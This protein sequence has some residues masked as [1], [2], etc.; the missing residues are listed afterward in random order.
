MKPSGVD[1]D[2]V[3]QEERRSHIEN[4]LD[5][6]GRPLAEEDIHAGNRRQRRD[7]SQQRTIRCKPSHGRSP[8]PR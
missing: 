5:Q 4:R 1:D 6:L 2:P 3:D 7:Q 8:L